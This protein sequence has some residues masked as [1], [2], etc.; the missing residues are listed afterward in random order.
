MLSKS[1]IERVLHIHYSG[2]EGMDMASIYDYGT[3]KPLTNGFQRIF[4][5]TVTSTE[6]RVFVEPSIG[7]T[8]AHIQLIAP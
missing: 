1:I 6:K 3:A 8:L 7:A 4:L 5:F 2:S